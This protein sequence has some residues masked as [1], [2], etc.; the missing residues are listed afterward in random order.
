MHILSQIYEI[1]PA[2]RAASYL[3]IHYSF[4]PNCFKMQCISIPFEKKVLE[5]IIMMVFDGLC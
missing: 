3:S 5:R 4:I 2:V 1:T